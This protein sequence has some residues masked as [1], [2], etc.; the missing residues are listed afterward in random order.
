MDETPSLSKLKNYSWI[1]KILSSV[2][3]VIIAS[4]GLSQPVLAA[5][6]ASPAQTK[7]QVM[8]QVAQVA[9]RYHLDVDLFLDVINCESGF[10]HSRVYGDSGK[11]YGISQFH[12]PTFLMFVKEAGFSDFDYYDMDDQLDLMAWSWH[13]GYQSHWSCYKKVNK[14]D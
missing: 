8:E 14:K 7:K 1:R 12:K 9:Q 10:R 2:I 3:C 11:A 4:L 6:S 5:S 13:Q